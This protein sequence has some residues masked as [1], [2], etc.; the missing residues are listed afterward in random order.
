MKKV[1]AKR[2]AKRRPAKKAYLKATEVDNNY[3][4]A[5]YNIGVMAMTDVN[6]YIKKQNALGYSKEDIRRA[7]ELEPII[8]K[9]LSEALPLWEKIVGM[10]VN[11]I[12]ALETLAYLYMMKGMERDAELVNAKIESLSR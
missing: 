1:A 11:D 9:S 3:Y 4:N 7:D 8:Q 5:H 6:Y 12:P 10:N 2:P